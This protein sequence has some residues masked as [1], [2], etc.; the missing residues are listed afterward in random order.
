MINGEEILQDRGTVPKSNVYIMMCF[1]QWRGD[2]P[3]G[4]RFPGEE[5]PL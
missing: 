5:I 1:N 2:S 4:R 3:M